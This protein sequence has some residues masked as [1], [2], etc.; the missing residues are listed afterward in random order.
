MDHR[1]HFSIT[2]S[3]A[4]DALTVVSITGEVDITTGAQF[5]R[6]LLRAIGAGREGLVVDLSRV[7]FLDSTA[8]TSLTRAFDHL[9]SKGGGRL[10]IVASDS[11]MRSLFDV[12]RLERDFL[13]CRNREEALAA[14]SGAADYE[15]SE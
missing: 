5:E 6:G 12:A 2:D 9:R 3:Q 13:I 8:L 7:D 15:R 4:S 11:R 1:A 14:V 10:A